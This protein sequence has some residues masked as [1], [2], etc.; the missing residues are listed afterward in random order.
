MDLIGRLKPLVHVMEFRLHLQQE[1]W[2]CIHLD[3][4]MFG[5]DFLIAY[6]LQKKTGVWVVAMLGSQN[7]ILDLKRGEKKNSNQLE[8]RLEVA[9]V[10]RCSFI[11]H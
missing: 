3:T 6:L 9:K 11:A 5:L 10:I 1:S 2:A 8:L 4:N 7:D